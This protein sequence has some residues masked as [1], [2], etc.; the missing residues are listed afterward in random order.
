MFPTSS[1]RKNWMLGSEEK[2]IER[3]LKA[4]DDF[5]AR[6]SEQKNLRFLTFDESEAVLKFFEQRLADFCNK[7]K[8]PMPRS[9]FGTALQ[10]YK[11]FYLSNSVMDYHP[12]EI[13]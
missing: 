5:I 3:R 4:Y 8:P 6:F 2:V 7:F 10:Y 12:K 11:R 9:T 13:L 1:Q